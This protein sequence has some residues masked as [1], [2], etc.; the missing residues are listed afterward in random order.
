LTLPSAGEASRAEGLQEVIKD[1]KEIV[2]A[3]QLALADKVGAERFELWFGANTRLALSEDSLVVGV[4]SP[5]FQDWLRNNFRREIE[6]SCLET[7]GRPVAVTFQVDVTLAEARPNHRNKVVAEGAEPAKAG[8]TVKL[9]HCAPTE[10]DD[11]ACGATAPRRRFADLESFVVGAGNRLARVS[12]ESVARRLG[13]SSPLVIHGPTSVGKTH[14]LE[15]IWTATKRANPS[16]HAVYLSAEQFTSYFLAALHGSGLPSFRR[17][18]RG[19]DLL[20]ID[21]VQ[22]LAG[23]KATCVELLHTV[24]TL[25]NEGRQL[26]FSADRAPAELSDLGPELRVRLQGGLACPIEPPDYETRLGIVRN[27]TVALAISVPDDVQGFVAAQINSHA[28]ALSGALKRLEAAS[29]AHHAP[30]TMA[31]AEETLADV[32][33]SHA[34]DIRLPDIEQAIC[35]AFGLEAKALKS[36]AV[37]RRVNHPRMLAM[38]LARKHTRAALAEIGSY[39]GG[40]SHSTVISA[41]K[42]VANWMSQNSSLELAGGQCNVEEAIRRVEESLRA[43]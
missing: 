27:M 20:I 28:R 22:F 2:S 9:A 24:D 29:M 5:F 41:Q 40:R 35:D 38:W 17:K 30:I 10:R 6:A 7:L 33:R 37:A 1:D 42:K 15:G 26:V 16:A 13:S 18:Y 32:I 12:A 8:A 34:R 23:K 36:A 3:L 43:G 4:P 31:L 21:D 25:L 14:L 19:V 39:F 11:R